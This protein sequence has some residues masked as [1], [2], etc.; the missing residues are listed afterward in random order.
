MMQRLQGIT[1][2]RIR[3]RSPWIISPFRYYREPPMHKVLSYKYNP[4][5]PLREIIFVPIVVRPIILTYVIYQPLHTCLC[6]IHIL[7]CVCI[8]MYICVRTKV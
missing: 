2:K 7:I 8:Y 5:T 3:E 1:A 6:N 4:H